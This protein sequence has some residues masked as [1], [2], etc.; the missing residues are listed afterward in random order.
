MARKLLNSLRFPEGRSP[1]AGRPN[2]SS[3]IFPCKSQTAPP[4]RAGGDNR[5][6][7]G[8]GSRERQSPQATRRANARKRGENPPGSGKMRSRQDWV[9]EREGFE[10]SRRFPAYTLSRRAPSTTRP[11]LRRRSQMPDPGPEC[12]AARPQRL[13]SG[14]SPSGRPARWTSAAG[15]RRCPRRSTGSCRRSGSPRGGRAGPSGRRASAR[16]KGRPCRP[17][18]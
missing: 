7:A 10:P 8:I 18:P 3:L 15:S 5:T 16:S 1:N 11:S 13:F 17:P 9:A 14:G 2:G 6:R 12:K 4:N